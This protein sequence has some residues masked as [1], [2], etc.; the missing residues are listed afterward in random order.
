[1][2]KI[3][4]SS[5]LVTLGIFA[6]SSLFAL[7]E[8]L[9]VKGNVLY[10][11]RVNALK[12]P[13]PVINVPVSVSIIT[14]DEI[15]RRGFTELG[16][17]VRY[18]PG[19]N[20]SQGEG[21][22]DAIVFR[23]N[24]S[25]ADFFQDGVRDDVQYYRSLYNVEQVEILR[26][27]NALLFGRGGTGG[28]VNRV[29]KKGVLGETFGSFAIGSDTFGAYDFTADYNILIN[30]NRSLR[31]MMHRDYL[32]N[33]RNYYDGDR[34]G[35]NPTLKVRLDDSTVLDVSYEYADHERFID[36]G[37]PTGAN[38]EPVETLA[39]VV[40][41]D[42]ELNS[43]TLT[44]DILR[45]SLTRDFSDTSKLIFTATISEFEKMY[46][47]L[48]AAGYDATAEE[49]A[50]DGYRDP[51]SR[52]NLIFSLNFVNEFKTRSATHTLLV[53][54]EIV[55]TDNANHRFNTY[56]TNAG[57]APLAND[58]S[59]IYS[60]MSQLTK[61][62]RETF[63]IS[64]IRAGV[65]NKDEAG[66]AVALD[67]TS[68]LSSKT[69]TEYEVTSI[70][71]QDQINFSDSLKLLIGG[72]YDDYEISVNDL[73]ASGTPVYTKT[74]DLF[75]PRAGLIFKP[76]ENMSVYLSYSDTFSPKAGE[77]Y[78]KMTNDST[79]GSVLDADEVENMEIGI[80]VALLDDLFI[81]AAYF[82]AESTQMK[83]RTVNSV[84]EQYGMVNK[85]VDGYE[86]E[87]S[88]RISDQ[89]DL[90][91]SYADFEGANV[92][93][94][95]EIPDY[96]FTAFASYQV[97]D[98]FGIGFGVTSQ[99]DSQIG[100]SATLYL[101]SYTRVDLAAYY[102]LADDLTIQANLE[103]LTDETYFP[104]SHS[105]HQASVGEEMNTRVSI[106]RT[107]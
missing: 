77:Q 106:R 1:L 57:A 105:T 103:N 63:L 2:K 61:Y 37:I 54:A 102:N 35:F 79:L 39:D 41:G 75:S 40:F 49:V 87:L 62:D 58:T 46:Q 71:I 21:H 42:P 92:A 7:E 74:E 95:R 55:E 89:L 24:R 72:R 97:S 8:E 94:S 45:A 13:V 9:F 5:L 50:L 86:I 56:F 60:G 38:G 98:D 6:S 101:P 81:T 31:I 104:H 19:V 93:Q 107:F 11:D 70:F 22:R 4:T 43:T 80:K 27:P 82:H 34:A 64:D 66:A 44:A 12:T 52:N 30:E 26:G 23:G 84:D 85:E 17:L 14:D 51:T 47:N 18:T 69:A 16:D 88:G 10:S 36:R 65:F 83:S 78:K 73:K 20:T 32:D 53:G 68:S 28:V 100:T 33:H 67:F 76:Q 25:T 29:S 15:A 48:Y 99:G 90:S 96:T 59:G 3:I 91:M